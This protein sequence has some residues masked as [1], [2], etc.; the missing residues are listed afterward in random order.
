MQNFDAIA[1][2]NAKFENTKMHKLVRMRRTGDAKKTFSDQYT[3][4]KMFN[5]IMQSRLEKNANIV[6]KKQHS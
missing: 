4:L 1:L 3:G 2:L 5:E 6:H